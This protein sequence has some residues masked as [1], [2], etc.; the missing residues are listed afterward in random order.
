[1]NTPHIKHVFVGQDGNKKI[2]FTLVHSDQRE[3]NTETVF[4]NATKSFDQ[5]RKA[6]LASCPQDCILH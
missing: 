1:M 6:V 3:I 4:Q 5:E 2:F